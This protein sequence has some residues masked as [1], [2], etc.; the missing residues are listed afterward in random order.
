MTSKSSVKTMSLKNAMLVSVSL[1]TFGNHRKDKAAAG[2]VAKAHQL[3]SDEVVRVY[4]SL[5]GE[6][7]DYSNVRAASLAI[8]NYVES[9]TSPWVYRGIRIIATDLL[10]DFKAQ[11]Q[12]LELN[13]ASKLEKMLKNYDSLLAEA[14]SRLKD[15]YNADKYPSPDVLKNAF[16][17]R[18]HY[19]PMPVA[20]TITLTGMSEEEI[21]QFRLQFKRDSAEAYNRAHK[22]TWEQAS[23]H[24]ERLYKALESNHRAVRRDTI[25]GMESKLVELARV[26]IVEDA[27]FD[28][29]VETLKST[30][31]H[32]DPAELKKDDA[33]RGALMKDLKNMLEFIQEACAISEQDVV[34]LT[35]AH[36]AEPS[37]AA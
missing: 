9:V 12:R 23:Q 5:F 10:P 18:L 14:Q 17:V 16:S 2:T 19:M 29:L 25:T 11:I 22:A 1:T 4:Y 28:S 32:A 3:D 26:S 21:E 24:I 6:T 27:C 7:E 8:R 36:F 34:D 15:L 20:S 31:K 13:L 30:L 33:A 35:D 37:K